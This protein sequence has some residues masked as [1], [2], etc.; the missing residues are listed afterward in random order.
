MRERH[1]WSSILWLVYSFVVSRAFGIAY[2]VKTQEKG[3]MEKKQ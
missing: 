3:R 2:P 1:E